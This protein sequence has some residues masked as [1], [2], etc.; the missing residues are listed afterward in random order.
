MVLTFGLKFAVNLCFSMLLKIYVFNKI[1]RELK[2][3]NFDYT[4]PFKFEPNFTDAC[5]VNFII[6]KT[7]YIKFTFSLK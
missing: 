1:T 6:T 4:D 5:M 3:F 2:I 7:L